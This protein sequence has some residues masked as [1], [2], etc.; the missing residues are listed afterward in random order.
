MGPTLRNTRGASLMKSG[1]LVFAGLCVVLAGAGA[2]VVRAGEVPPNTAES[3]ASGRALFRLHCT[4]CHGADGRAQLDVIANA[5]D[6]TEPSL[7]LNGS[8]EAD[9][10]RSIHD[11]AGVAMPAWGAQLGADAVGE[12]VNFVRSLW[13]EGQRPPV[14][15]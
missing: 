6:L 4:Q 14:V 12:L 9:V 10:Y 13:P 3:I 7:Y 8:T 5:T 2:A 1:R 15:P 11:G